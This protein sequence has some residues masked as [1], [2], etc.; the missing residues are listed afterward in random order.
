VLEEKQVTQIGVA[1][2]RRGRCIVYTDNTSCGACAEHCPVKAVRMEPYKDSL[3]LPQVYPELCIGCGGCESICP[4][5][6]VKAI[7]VV[8]NAVHAKAERFE[9]EER[10]QIDADNLDF[11][12]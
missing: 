4:V 5:R 7:N 2:F 1:E 3:T 12:F 9:E 10:E 6:P 11:G 8:P